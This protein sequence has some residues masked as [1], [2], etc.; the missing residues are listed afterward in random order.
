MLFYTESLTDYHSNSNMATE[1]VS[2]VD[3]RSTNSTPLSTSGCTD[4]EAEYIHKFIYSP[5]TKEA[6]E[7]LPHA[8]ASN[9]TFP[10]SKSKTSQVFKV[11]FAVKKVSLFSFSRLISLFYYY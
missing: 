3:N 2:C 9:G 1:C 4:T 7:A 10:T 6:N 8:D 11:P 5:Q